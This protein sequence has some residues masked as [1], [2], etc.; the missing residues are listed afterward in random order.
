MEK[1]RPIRV[2]LAD[3]HEVVLEGHEKWLSD[4]GRFAVV[5]KSRTVEEAV[6]L[7][8]LQKPDIAVV[9]LRFFDRD[10]PEICKWIKEVS[11]G[12]RVA[13]YSAFSSAEQ[14]SAAFQA[15]ADG[16]FDKHAEGAFLPEVVEQLMR[17]EPVLDSHILASIERFLGRTETG[18]GLMKLIEEWR[19]E[20][21]HRAAKRTLDVLGD[22][23]REIVRVLAEKGMHGKYNAVAAQF[24]FKTG[25]GLKDALYRIRRRLN[26]A[27]NEELTTLWRRANDVA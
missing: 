26:V 1:K 11:P 13:M 6:E 2:V 8:R 17:G 18:L 14:V 25:D 23:E 16:Y 20:A 19:V 5:G 10:R 21:E 7:C 4:D 27:S 12:T 15:G 9:D 3:D 24:G 22:R